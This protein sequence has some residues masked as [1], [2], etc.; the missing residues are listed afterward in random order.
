[1]NFYRFLIS[2]FTFLC[3]VR[4]HQA[5]IDI[6]NQK[7]SIFLKAYTE[8]IRIDYAK[9]AKNKTDVEKLAAL[10]KNVFIDKLSDPEL[11]AFWINAYNFFAIKTVVEHYPI[12]SPKQV[13]G[14]FT[15]IKHPLRGINITLDD[16][17]HK[18]ILAVHRDPRI[19]FAL[20]CA[21][22]GCPRITD[23]PYRGASIEQQL[24][25]Q[26]S[27]A[28]NDSY[29]I[30]L[31][32]EKNQ[33][34]LS[35][36]FRWYKNDFTRKSKDLI[37]FLN[38]YRKNKI[39]PTADIK[40][41]DYDWTLNDT[42]I[43]SKRDK[44]FDSSALRNKGGFEIKSYNTVYTQTQEFSS[45]F[46]RTATDK[47]STWFT[48]I[49][50]FYYGFHERWNF[51]LDL[52]VRSVKLDP[53]F[54]SSFNVFGFEANRP[55]AHAAL[56]GIV[57][58]VKF[59]PIKSLAYLSMQVSLT[60]PA[61]SNFEGNVDPKHPFLEHDAWQIW[62]EVYYDLYIGD[63]FS[64][65][66]ALGLSSRFGW[67]N[68]S[69]NVGVGGYYKTFFQYFLSDVFTFYAVGEIFGLVLNGGLGVKILIDRAFQIE[70]VVTHSLIGIGKG[71]GTTYSLGVSY[72]H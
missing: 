60:I 33:L 37:S 14:F 40:W 58:K 27:L 11:K 3:L 23:E 41:K 43:N 16:I 2:A 53:S 68:S 32:Q 38:L 61:G 1:M 26:T 5:N 4:P 13:S 47:R 28:V 8:G 64:F 51:G 34:E 44:Y 10:L 70:T 46:Q 65:F 35:D 31:N 29:F 49:T 57:P 25:T 30:R 69:T 63:S 15:S 6:F 24:Q 48:S 9:V 36:L 62:Y 45:L 67:L 18:K 71:V 50:G 12:Y 39:P 17:E 56:T 22:R 72:S 7:Y 42:S 59:A 54:G 20:V 66:F 55:N 52:W 21:S 19:H